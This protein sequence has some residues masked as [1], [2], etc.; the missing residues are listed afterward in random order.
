M[1]NFLKINDRELLSQKIYRIT[2]QVIHLYL[3][4]HI[5]HIFEN[6]LKEQKENEKK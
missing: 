3:Q 1:A 2:K 4:N 5:T 6:G